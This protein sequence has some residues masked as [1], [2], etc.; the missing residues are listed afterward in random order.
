MVFDFIMAFAIAYLWSSGAEY[1]TKAANDSGRSG[2]LDRLLMA[3]IGGASLFGAVVREWW[4]P[5]VQMGGLL[6]H[7]VQIAYLSARFKHS[8]APYD[9]KII[10]RIISFLDSRKPIQNHN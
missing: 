2:K 3:L 10:G 8:K 1:M 6:I 7:L 4:I 5:Y 9:K